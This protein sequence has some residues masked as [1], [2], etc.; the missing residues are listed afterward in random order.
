MLCE[1]TKK[2][3]EETCV[4]DE[5][6]EDTYIKDSNVE[7]LISNGATEKANRA[8]KKT[9]YWSIIIIAVIMLG[10]V[11]YFLIKRGWAFQ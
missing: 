1:L 4:E 8:P 6:T 10:L 2:R 3:T 11:V 5:K 7:I 9:D